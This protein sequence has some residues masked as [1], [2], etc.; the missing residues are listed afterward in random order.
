MTVYGCV[1]SPVFECP[2]KITQ[3]YGQTGLS[4]PCCCVVLCLSETAAGLGHCGATVRRPLSAA[5]AR[6]AGM[7]EPPASSP[8]TSGPS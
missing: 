3:H 4:V 5:A 8:S 2:S 7:T 6:P 1:L